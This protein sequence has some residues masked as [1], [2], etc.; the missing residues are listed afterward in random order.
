MI[1][2]QNGGVVEYQMLKTDQKALEINQRSHLWTLQ[3]LVSQEGSK[4]LF[5]S[6]WSSSGNNCKN[7]VLVWTKLIP[8][9]FTG[10][11]HQTDMFVKID[12][13]RCSITNGLSWKNG[14]RNPDL[15]LPFCVCRYCSSNKLYAY[16][17]RQWLAWCQISIVSR[18]PNQ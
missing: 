1:Y 4:K 17:Q 18:W 10:L 14:S 6:G 7:H 5:F 13:I 9:P 8:T 15:T 2:K 12:S 16:H 11:S 3:K